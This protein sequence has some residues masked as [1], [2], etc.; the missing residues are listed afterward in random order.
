MARTQTPVQPT[1]RESRLLSTAEA[2][3]YIGHSRDFVRRTLRNE[4]PFV[5]HGFKGP[6]RFWTT[7]LDR[8][9]D[10]HTTQPVK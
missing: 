7:D 2:A 6:L 5:Q 3:L 10:R 9:L 4:C 1:E 8:W